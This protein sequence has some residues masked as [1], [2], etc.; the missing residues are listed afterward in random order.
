MNSKIESLSYW[1][2]MVFLLGLFKIPLIGY[3]K[4]KVIQ[5]D[6]TTVKVKIRIR[7]RTKNHLNS[8]YFG[9]LAIGAD[10]AGG[11]HAFYFAEEQGRKVSFA[12]K[13]MKFIKTVDESKMLNYYKGPCVIISASGMADAGRVKHHISNNI[14]NSRN[15]IVL[16]GYCEPSSLGARLLR[17]PKEVGIFGQQHEVNAEI[18]EMRSMSAHGDYEDLM[19]FLA[20]QDPKLV[21]KLFLVHGEYNVQEDFKQRLLRKGFL[22]VEIPERHSEV[23]LG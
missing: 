1:K 3:V 13:G 17:K 7:R 22:D 10:V 15:S 5:V 9:A 18:G 23:G 14:E 6:A 8:M 4:P 21:Q 16:T 11:V 12:F 2:R 19:Q 20:C